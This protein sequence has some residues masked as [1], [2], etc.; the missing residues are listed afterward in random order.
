MSESQQVH[1]R[2]GRPS[3]RRLHNVLNRAGQQDIN[4]SDIQNIVDHCKQCQLHGKSPGRFR[5]TL[6]DDIEYNYAVIVDVVQLDGNQ[7]LHVDEAIAFNAARFLPNMSAK[8]AFDTLRMCWIDVY[9]GPMESMAVETKEVPVEAHNSVGKV[10]RYDEPPRRAYAI[11]RSE[12][13]QDSKELI[14]QMAVEATNDTADPNGYVPTL[15]VFGAYP[16][17]HTNSLP[18]LG[19]IKR[20]E[21]IKTAM[22][23]VHKIHAQRKVKDA[24]ALRNGPNVTDTFS[25]PLNSDILVYREKRGW[26]GPWK[27]LGMEGTR[28]T[29]EMPYGPVDFRST[30][31]KAY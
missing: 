31:V 17:M 25:L 4:S 30:V 19:I 2:F 18:T 29:V 15:L 1:R 13:P 6:R 16:R 27:L 10:E 28:C 22:N 9:N 14:L 21:A 20:A 3:V 24:L 11:L 23:E 5:F 8:A 26:T 7:V 12:L